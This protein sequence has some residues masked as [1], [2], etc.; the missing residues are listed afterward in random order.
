M[1]HATAWLVLRTGGI[2]CR[3]ARSGKCDLIEEIR[4]QINIARRNL[5]FGVPTYKTQ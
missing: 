2:E 3:V 5:V 4:L 1:D